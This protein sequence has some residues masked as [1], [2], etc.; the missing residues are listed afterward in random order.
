VYFAE[1]IESGLYEDLLISELL[2]RQC[3]VV[4]PI[5]MSRILADEPSY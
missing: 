3:G 2:Q 1:Y 5:E 4:G